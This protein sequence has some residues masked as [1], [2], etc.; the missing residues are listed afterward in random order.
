MKKNRVDPNPTHLIIVLNL[1][2]DVHIFVLSTCR[3][4]GSYQILPTLLQT[5]N[6][7]VWDH[8]LSTTNLT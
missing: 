5:I 6:E 8:T 3:L 4:I 7:N 1:M 2:T